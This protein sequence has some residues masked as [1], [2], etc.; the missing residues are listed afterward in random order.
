MGSRSGSLFFDFF[1]FLA[2]FSVLGF[3]RERGVLD[4]KIY[5]RARPC[6]VEERSGSGR[7]KKAKL[8]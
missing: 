5:M 2:F 3:G 7:L 6:V 8:I 4:T 1:F